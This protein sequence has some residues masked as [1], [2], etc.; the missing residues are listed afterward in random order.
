MT[1]QSMCIR[2]RADTQ[3]DL[4]KLARL[5]YLRTLNIRNL[6]LLRKSDSKKL[7]TVQRCENLALNV[8]QDFLSRHRESAPH[9][10]RTIAIGA[11]TYVDT[12]K[13]RA[14]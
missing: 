3:Q 9:P 10:L 7:I 1:K 12:W 11:M 8:A 14:E 6:P 5:K 4:C 2:H 13:G